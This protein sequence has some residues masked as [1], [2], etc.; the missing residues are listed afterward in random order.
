MLSKKIEDA[1]N[2]QITKEANATFYYLAMASWAQ[3][4]ALDGTASFLYGHSNEENMHM[5]KIFNY[6][7]E[8]GGHALVPEIKNVRNDYKSIEE[9]FNLIL[10]SELAVTQSVNN[11][12]SMCYEEK[13][14][15]TLNFMQWFV[16]EQHEEE[17]LFRRILDKIKL[18]GTDFKGIYTL[19]KEIGMIQVGGASQ[20]GGHGR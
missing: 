10:E 18:I 16:A 7:N 15:A 19:D 17:V 2:A 4:Q 6:I 5:H 11:I 20:G 12:V 8:T 13:D 9:V 3:S 1:L 14:Y